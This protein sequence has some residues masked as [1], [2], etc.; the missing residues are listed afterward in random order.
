MSRQLI[1]TNNHV[2]VRFPFA[3]LKRL[4]DCA[5]ATG[6]NV[7]EYIRQAVAEKMGRPSDPVD[8]AR[9]MPSLARELVSLAHDAAER[10]QALIREVETLKAARSAIADTLAAAHSSLLAQ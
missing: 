4:E 5:C 8:R 7:S 2:A 9:M 6:T 1:G 3:E 10:E